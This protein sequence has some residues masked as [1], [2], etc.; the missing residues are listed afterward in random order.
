[1]ALMRDL[2]HLKCPTCG[3]QHLDAIKYNMHLCDNLRAA[4][5][6]FHVTIGGQGHVLNKD[7]WCNPRIA[8]VPMKTIYV[9]RD[10][11]RDGNNTRPV[12]ASR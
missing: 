7:C 9:H 5:G 12:E 8:H 11:E 10:K 6:A 2:Y 4:D 3:Q 1:M